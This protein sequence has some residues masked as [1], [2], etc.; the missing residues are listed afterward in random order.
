MAAYCAREHSLEDVARWL[1]KVD[2]MRLTTG[3]EL[4]AALSSVIFRHSQM[5][6]TLSATKVD[7]Q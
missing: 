5:K 4:S 6:Q 1:G 2:I 3:N 7:L